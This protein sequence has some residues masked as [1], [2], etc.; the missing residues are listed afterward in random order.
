MNINYYGL[1]V[2]LIIGTSILDTDKAGLVCV[3]II[4]V[5][6]D[7]CKLEFRVTHLTTLSLLT[8]IN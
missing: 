7:N 4:Y 8:T 6:S 3:I 5:L 1:I 2:A